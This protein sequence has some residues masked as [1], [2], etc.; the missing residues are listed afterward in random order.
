MELSSL[1]KTSDDSLS[2]TFMIKA[3]SCPFP[4]GLSSSYSSNFPPGLESHI[5]PDDFYEFILGL[6]EILISN[7]PCTYILVLSFTFAIFTF[8][9]SLLIPMMCIREAEEAAEKYL[10][11]Q[12]KGRLARCG[13]FAKLV[14][15]TCGGHIEIKVIQRGELELSIE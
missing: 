15:G 5:D 10:R 7:W 6:N 2:N 1:I 4:N 13:L 12:N 8:G 3:S 9:L 11:N 14:K